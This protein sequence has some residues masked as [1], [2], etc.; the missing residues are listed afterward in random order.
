MNQPALKAPALAAA[1]NDRSRTMIG[2]PW[3]GSYHVQIDVTDRPDTNRVL[4]ELESLGVSARVNPG[5]RDRLSIYE[6]SSLEKLLELG[7]QLEQPV[8]ERLQ[9]LVWARGP[10]PEATGQFIR[11]Q[12]S[13]ERSPQA[14]AAELN[15]RRATKGVG[16]K[17]W[18]PRKVLEAAKGETPARLRKQE[19][20]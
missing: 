1:L 19:A 17:G 5:I 7:E 14:I 12:L 16:G 15:R 11:D 10:V 9:K 13:M 20:A 4:Q 3:R 8:R 18:T 2:D 6:L